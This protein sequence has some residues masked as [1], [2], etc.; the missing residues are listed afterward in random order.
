MILVDYSCK[1]TYFEGTI[2]FLLIAI[3]L[4]FLSFQKYLLGWWRKGIML[5][6]VSYFFQFI[7]FLFVCSFVCLFVCLLMLLLLISF[8]L[9]FLFW[10]S[11][12]WIIGIVDF[13]ILCRKFVFYVNSKNWNTDQSFS[14][15]AKFSKKLAF[16]TLWPT[17]VRVRIR[18]KRH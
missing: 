11:T 14:T 3:T 1:I 10:L 7:A 13:V 4:L 17:H 2:L 6:F 5:N 9:S 8:F 12:F 15:Y 18:G 16:L